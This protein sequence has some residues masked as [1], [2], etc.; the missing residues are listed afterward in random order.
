MINA[1][2]ARH[3]PAVAT[4]LVALAATLVAC[5]SSQGP[6]LPSADRAQ[7]DTHLAEL[8]TSAGQHD[9]AGA[10]RQLDAF[11]GDVARAKSAGRLTA[12]A[13]AALET[14]IAR[15]RARIGVD[16]VAPPAAPTTTTPAVATTTQAPTPAPTP[17]VVA[18]VP[19]IKAPKAKKGPGGGG[20]GPGAGKHP[21]KGRGGH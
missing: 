19:L 1:M 21:G 20:F 14:G 11:A 6:V 4:A 15:S 9:V 2:V 13:Y 3:R 10:T 12:T 17:V 8:Q 16:V 7:M 5:G 18:P